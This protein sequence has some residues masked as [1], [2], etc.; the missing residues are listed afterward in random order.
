MDENNNKAPGKGGG[1][2]RKPKPDRNRK[3]ITAAV[4]SFAVIAVLLFLNNFDWDKR[5][6]DTIT[7]R[8]AP[9]HDFVFAKPD[10][11]TD[12][13]KDP[14]YLDKN[15]YILYTDGA[16]SALITDD[17]Y[18]MYSDTL[19]FFAEYFDAAKNGD[20]ERLN[21]LFTDEYWKEH[22]KYSDLTM[23]RIYNIEITLL[24]DDTIVDGSYKGYRRRTYDIGYMIMK[25]DGLFRSDMDS[26]SS[27]PLV[28]ELLTYGGVTKINSISSYN[29]IVYD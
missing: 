13:F 7:S 1:L 18:L 26:D 15:L 3:L 9:R 16:E 21:V 17:N 19:V 12:I 23:Q 4:I 27:V 2:S 14:Q 25:N 28:F 22:N 20:A 8:K 6:L 10:Y 24:T 5:V 11:D 29:Y